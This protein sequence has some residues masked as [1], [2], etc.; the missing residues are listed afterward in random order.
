M[1]T[2]R[3]ESNQVPI[4]DRR[5]QC[6]QR[7]LIEVSNLPPYFVLVVLGQCLVL[8]VL[9]WSQDDKRHAHNKHCFPFAHQGCSWFQVSTGYTAV[10]GTWPVACTGL[11]PLSSTRG[12]EAVDEAVT[13]GTRP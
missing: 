8:F 3:T 9:P 2:S 12:L 10:N 6:Y 4:S 13:L 7:L 1:T 5:R 11:V